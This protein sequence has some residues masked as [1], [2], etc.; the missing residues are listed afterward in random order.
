MNFDYLILLPKTNY[1]F[2]TTEIDYQ[3]Y[4]IRFLLLFIAPKK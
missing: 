4:V 2:F 3:I 1:Q